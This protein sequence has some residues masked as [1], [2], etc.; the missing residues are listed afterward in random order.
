MNKQANIFSK[1]KSKSVNEA[2]QEGK[3]MAWRGEEMLSAGKECIANDKD[4]NR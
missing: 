1:V 4:R 3:R 2:S